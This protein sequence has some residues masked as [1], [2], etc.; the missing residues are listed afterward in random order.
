[1]A[2]AAAK[3]AILVK[4]RKQSIHKTK[5]PLLGSRISLHLIHPTIDRAHQALNDITPQ[6]IDRGNLLPLRHIIQNINKRPPTRSVCLGPKVPSLLEDGGVMRRSAKSWKVK[7]S[8]ALDAV[9]LP[10]LLGADLE[11]DSWD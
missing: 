1:M 10:A 7:S 5:C 4:E 2:I 3:Y 8:V 9:L 11:G 6:D